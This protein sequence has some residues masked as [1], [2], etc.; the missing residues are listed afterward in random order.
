MNSSP[1]VPVCRSGVQRSCQILAKKDLQSQVG[2]RAD[3]VLSP[4]GAEPPAADAKGDQCGMEQ[5]CGVWSSAVP[6]V[7]WNLPQVYLESGVLPLSGSSDKCLGT[8][9]AKC[10][11]CPGAYGLYMAV[12]LDIPE[13]KWGICPGTYLWVVSLCRYSCFDH[14]CRYFKWVSLPDVSALT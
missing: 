8:P 6:A 7:V 12:L 9:D 2:I 11:I 1:R 4:A 5:R 14:T 3:K 13:D 10:G